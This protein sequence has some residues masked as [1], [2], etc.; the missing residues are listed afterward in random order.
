MI[1]HISTNL[2]IFPLF[3]TY[4]CA[5][6]HCLRTRIFN[7]F[8]HN[9]FDSDMDLAFYEK[10]DWVAPCIGHAVTL[11]L[12]KIHLIAKPCI[13]GC[14]RTNKAAGYFEMLSIQNL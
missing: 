5:E 3:R 2:V 14:R 6:K 1:S 11:E 8:H 9:G 13:K 10:V 12:F 7:T 4:M